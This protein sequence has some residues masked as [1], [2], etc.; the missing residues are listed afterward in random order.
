M[1]GPGGRGQEHERAKAWRLHRVPA[2]HRAHRHGPKL[3][4]DKR[5]AMKHKGEIMAWT[6]GPASKADPKVAMQE[7]VEMRADW[8]ATA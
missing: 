4:Q 3:L 6:L 5:G 7:E 1:K 2:A 8:V